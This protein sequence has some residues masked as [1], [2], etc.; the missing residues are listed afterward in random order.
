MA[1]QYGLLKTMNLLLVTLLSSSLVSSV[2]A[3]S[4]PSSL[5]FVPAASESFPAC[6]V[7]C[8]RLHQVKTSCAASNDQKDALACFC[9]SGLLGDLHHSP[10]GTC[11]DSCSDSSDRE[12]LQ[13][14]FL[15]QCL[16]GDHTKRD[17]D[18]PEG[19]A[20]HTLVAREGSPPNWYV[21]TR[22]KKTVNLLLTGFIQV[23]QSLPV[24]CDGYRA[25]YCLYGSHGSGGLA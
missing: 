14:W 9:G 4:R 7:D 3:Q 8:S 13:S 6:A 5:S 20:G 1:Q 16:T 24:G 18:S 21:L 11:D 22:K 2:H 12:T 25:Y 19:N 17:M 23:G 10:N 15:N